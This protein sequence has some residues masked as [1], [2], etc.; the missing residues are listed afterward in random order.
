MDDRKAIHFLFA[1]YLSHTVK[2]TPNRF[3]T[4]QLIGETHYFVWSVISDVV[5]VDVTGVS[6]INVGVDT[7]WAR[8]KIL[9]IPFT[10]DVNNA[11][12]YHERKL[13]VKTN[14]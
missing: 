2:P 12:G 9:G 3:Q 6:C 11:S 8:F 7:I 1:L 4:D 14:G 13:S 10:L 5:L